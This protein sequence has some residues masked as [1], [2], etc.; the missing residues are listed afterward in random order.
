MFEI[1]VGDT[2]IKKKY[3]DSKLQIKRFIIFKMINNLIFFVII[4]YT[5]FGF[6][7]T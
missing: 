2:K 5:Y 6:I 4:H 3:F 7:P 1:I